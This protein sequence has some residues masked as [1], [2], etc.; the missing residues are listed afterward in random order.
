MGNK[1]IDTSC[2]QYLFRICMI[3]STVVVAMFVPQYGAFLSFLGCIGNAATIFW[4]PSA[5]YL[6]RYHDGFGVLWLNCF[7][8]GNC[9]IKSSLSPYSL[10]NEEAKTNEGSIVG[11]YM[12]L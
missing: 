6:M 7:L 3:L 1:W 11:K 12:A 4:L 10:L 2:K 8:C 5:C 9:K